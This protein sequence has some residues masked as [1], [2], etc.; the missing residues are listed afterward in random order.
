MSHVDIWE[1]RIL[2]RGNSQN[3]GSEVR[4]HAVHLRK[5]KEVGGME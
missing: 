1:K 3:K 2:G 4:L 5:S